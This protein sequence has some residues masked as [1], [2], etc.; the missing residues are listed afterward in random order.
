MANATRTV[1]VAVDAMGGDHA[2]DE[3][4][5]GVAELSLEAKHIQ[6]LLVGDGERVTRLL[7]TLRHDPERIAVHHAP[8]AIRMDESPRTA[9]EARPDSSICVAARLVA[10]G[11]A[12][13]LVSAGN[14]GAGVLACSR[15]WRRIPGVRRAA[16]AAV[17]PTEIRR[18]EKDDPFSLLLDVGASNEV[19]AEDLVAFALMG[20]AY[21]AR[22]AKN[23]RPRVALLSNGT[24]EMKGPKE[25]V[26][27]HRLLKDHTAINF[28]GNVEGVDIPRGTADV[29]VTSGF[30]GNVVL[31]ML[32]GVSETVLSLAR[33]AYKER[34]VW[35]LGLMMLSGGISRLKSV[36]DWEEY[37]GAPLLGFDRL[38]IKAHGRSRARAIAN[39]VKVAAKG[40]SS[41]LVDEMGRSLA[42][43]EASRGGGGAA[44]RNAG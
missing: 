43:F 31:K 23:P 8:Q 41:G 16:L 4:V 7:S 35:R 9:I 29:I 27:A 6:I 36:T 24:E 34:L 28:V 19:G 18:G 13:A 40:A 10:D 14:T 5:R 44:D 33:Y 37:G 22:I 17:Y 21:A 38:F 15:A 26:E 11:E 32:E 20:S 39:A 1:T 25:I 12:E 2:P 42:A 30:V 3:V